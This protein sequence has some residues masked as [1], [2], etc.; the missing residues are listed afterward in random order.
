MSGTAD[1]YALT[2]ERLSIIA[3]NFS[4]YREI[5][6][7]RLNPTDEN[8]AAAQRKRAAM[9]R[10]RSQRLTDDYLAIVV[11]EWRARSTEPDPMNAMAAAR[12]MNR[13]TLRRQLEEAERRGLM[14]EGRPRRTSKNRA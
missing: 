1:D 7:D 12:E 5:A 2:M 9:G 10:R 13:H 14:P 3:N 4:R 8:V 11:S 6:K